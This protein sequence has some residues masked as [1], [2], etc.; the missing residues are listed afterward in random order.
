MYKGKNTNCFFKYIFK[1][2][3]LHY[4]D[5]ENFFCKVFEISPSYYWK[6]IS[7][8]TEQSNTH[9]LWITF[10][11]IKNICIKENVK[12]IYSNILSNKKIYYFNCLFCVPFMKSV[13]F[14]VK[15]YMKVLTEKSSTHLVWIYYHT[16]MLV[17][18]KHVN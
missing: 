3:K 11:K 18:L 17:T 1:Y 12:N 14:L 5:C 8:L 7:V 13:H 6:K 2:R 4:F 10:N 16:K 9:L 15:K